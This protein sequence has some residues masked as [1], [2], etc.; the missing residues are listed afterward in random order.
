MKT[1]LLIQDT[2]DIPGA[3]PLYLESGPY[4]SFLPQIGDIITVNTAPRAPKGAGGGDWTVK[5]EYEVISRKY[6]VYSM[7]GTDDEMT[8]E[9]TVVKLS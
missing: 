5:G 7:E 3:D 6:D 1:Y 4:Q 2:D 8:C 9:L